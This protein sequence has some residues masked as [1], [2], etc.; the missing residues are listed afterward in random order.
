VREVCD[1]GGRV[2]FSEKK[3]NIIGVVGRQMEE[4]ILETK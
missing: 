1:Q 2:L 4:H 3:V